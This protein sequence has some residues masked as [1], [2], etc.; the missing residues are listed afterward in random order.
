MA[1]AMPVIGDWYQKPGGQLFE[2]VAIDD[3]DNTIEIQFFDGSV[4]EV[5][6]EAWYDSNFLSAVAPED[7]SGSLDIEPEDYGVELGVAGRK[8]WADPLDYLDQAE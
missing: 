6:L 1:I 3:E 7:Y 5:D 8:D 2:V 4:A